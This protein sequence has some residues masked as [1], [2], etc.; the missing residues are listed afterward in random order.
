MGKLT[1]VD[2]RFK[3]VSE[4]FPKASCSMNL[5]LCHNSD[6]AMAKAQKDG[7]YSDVLKKCKEKLQKSK[8][9][10]NNQRV[11]LFAQFSSQQG[12]KVKGK[13]VIVKV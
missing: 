9:Q 10:I 11:G 1:I 13:H 8:I 2:V 4:E 5:Q 6:S 3:A 12:I 7:K